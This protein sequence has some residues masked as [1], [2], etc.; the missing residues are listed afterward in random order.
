MGDREAILVNYG[1]RYLLNDKGEPFEY[2]TYDVAK[3]LNIMRAPQWVKYQRLRKY[4]SITPGKPIP[5]Y[6]DQVSILKLLTT[7]RRVIPKDL[8]IG[9][10]LSPYAIVLTTEQTYIGIIVN[11]FKDILDIKLQFAVGDYKVDAYIPEL[12]L[13]VECDEFGHQDIDLD[14]ENERQLF[15]EK[16]IGCTFLRFNPHDSAFSIGNVINT[17]NKMIIKK[18]ENA[19]LSNLYHES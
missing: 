11:S 6:I 7:V 13:A 3:I 12:K 16:T 19:T 9:F 14:Y 15:I 10:G 5:A 17:I 4:L 1:I 18:R 8:Y 2:N